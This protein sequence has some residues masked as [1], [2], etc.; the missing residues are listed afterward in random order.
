MHTGAV[1]G[2][3]PIFVALYARASVY[4]HAKVQMASATG[5]PASLL[6][7]SSPTPVSASQHYRGRHP[8]GFRHSPLVRSE[9]NQAESHQLA[10]PKT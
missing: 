5:H 1:Q 3:A 8:Q 2:R 6:L 9:G 4:M 7:P 10:P